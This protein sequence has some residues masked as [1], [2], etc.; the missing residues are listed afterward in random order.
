[1]TSFRYSMMAAGSLLFGG[2]ASL[3]PLSTASAA[4]LGGNC[5]RDLE[6]RVAE[7]EATTARKGNTKV[8]LTVYGQVNKA[9]LAWND[10]KDGDTYVVDNSVSS[11]RFGFMGKA[12]MTPG[13]SAGYNIEIELRD[14]YSQDGVDQD[15][16][17]MPNH[18]TTTGFTSSG[19]NVSALRLRQANWYVEGEKYGRVTVGLQN[20]ATKDGVNLNLSNSLSS[21]DNFWSWGFKVRR[22]NRPGPAN[23]WVNYV[24]GL[25]TGREH[26]VRYDTP[27]ILGFILSASWGENDAWDIALRYAKEWNGI[28]IAAYGGYAWTADTATNNISHNTHGKRDQ[29]TAAASVMHVPTGLYVNVA[30]GEQDADV[31]AK[32][33]SY[34]YGQLGIERKLLPLGATT[35][36]GEAGSYQDF[37]SNTSLLAYDANGAAITYGDNVQDT[38]KV[39]TSD[40]TRWGA[41][42]TQKVDS[43]ALDLYL[44]YHHYE[45]DVTTAATSVTTTTAV[46]ASTLEDWDAVVTGARIKF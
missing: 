38:V 11:S 2:F 40:V 39:V 23:N 45:A 7:L 33:A 13:F 46:R 9:L 30:G 25:D 27:S 26:V 44:Q 20:M 15:T 14:D 16:K 36:Y 12:K 21:A 8:S 31:R 28:K 37:A 10:G 22:S 5:C 24:H 42:V 35:V 43:A 32:T 41:G 17:N 6:Q 1:M 29:W 19:A 4:D 3:T 18:S 34:V